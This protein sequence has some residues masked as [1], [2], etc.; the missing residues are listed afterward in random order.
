MFGQNSLVGGGHRLATPAERG[1]IRTRTQFQS[2]GMGKSTRGG[3]TFI[4]FPRMEV[5]LESVTMHIKVALDN[6]FI[7]VEVTL[8][9]VLDQ[10]KVTLENVFVLCFR[11]QF[12]RPPPCANQTRGG[13]GSRA[14]A[15][16]P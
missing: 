16:W 6:V 7:L 10:A 15:R 1:C 14:C 8:K 13:A 3:G 12:D 5:A 4:G 11:R 9:N 2:Q